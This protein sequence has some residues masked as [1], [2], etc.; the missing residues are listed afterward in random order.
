MPYQVRRMSA[1]DA[2][3]AWEWARQEGWNPGL[4][5]CEIVYSFDPRGCFAGFLNGEMISSISAVNYQGKYGFLGLFIV[6]PK[7]RGHGYGL[8]IWKYAMDYLN[9]EVGVDCIGL[10]GVLANESLY[11]MSGFHTAYRV[12]RYRYVVSCSFRRE[13][14]AVSEQG[15]SDIASYDARVFRLD[16]APFLHDFIFKTEAKTAQAYAGGKLV[17]FAAARPCF[18]GYKIG[19]FFADDIEIAARL[20][21]SLF[22]DLQ[23][24]TVFI[25]VPEPN[26]QAVKLVN[27]FGMSPSFPTA[28]MYTGDKHRQD[29]RHVYGITSR[30][31]G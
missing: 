4:H 24:K 2:R 13:C 7:F 16:R 11:E 20:A 22:A 9:N 28:R 6:T 14:P 19:P 23:G 21:E 30:V 5:D 31:T 29:I 8:A 15:F 3:Q 27:D 17:G 25:E 12:S 26:D 10:D 18:E 1:D